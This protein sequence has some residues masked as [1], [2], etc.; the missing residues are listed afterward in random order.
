MCPGVVDDGQRFGDVAFGVSC[1]DDGV[2][3]VVLVELAA[4]C[5]WVSVVVFIVSVFV[6]VL[7]AVLL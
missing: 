2:G 6:L 4:T 1:G 7:F 3:E 5:E